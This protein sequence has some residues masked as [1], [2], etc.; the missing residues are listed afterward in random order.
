MKPWLQSYL[1]GPIDLPV[2]KPGQIKIEDVAHA[3][4][5]KCRFA[6]MTTR[7]YSVAEH[8]LRGTALLPSAFQLPFLLHELS[9]VALPDIPAPLKPMVRVHWPA[10]GGIERLAG[11]DGKPGRTADEV[12][13]VE[14]ERFHTHAILEGLGLLSIE[15]LIYSPEVKQMDLAMLAWEKNTVMASCKAEGYEWSLPELAANVVSLDY[16][17]ASSFKDDEEDWAITRD[18][19]LRCYRE[20]TEVSK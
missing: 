11:F 13:W 5:M 2:P 16:R 8:C 20:L 18:A 4:A 10:V 3:L 1:G 14:L 17:S 7:F 12:D 15:S 19:F 6:G 9:E